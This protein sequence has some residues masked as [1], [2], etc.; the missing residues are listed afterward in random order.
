M[1]KKLILGAVYIGFTLGGWDFSLSNLQQFLFLSSIARSRSPKNQSIRRPHRSPLLLPP[2]NRLPRRHRGHHLLGH[3]LRAW[4]MAP[5]QERVRLFVRSPSHGLRLLLEYPWHHQSL[6]VQ[7]C[8]RHQFIKPV[9]PYGISCETVGKCD[10]C[11]FSWCKCMRCTST[12]NNAVSAVLVSKFILYDYLSRSSDST[13][14]V[15]ESLTMP[16]KSLM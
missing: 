9:E 16:L 4:Q 5:L 12:N 11:N 13:S 1:F 2:G 6:H 15:D 8:N 14:L 10:S 3:W 7:S